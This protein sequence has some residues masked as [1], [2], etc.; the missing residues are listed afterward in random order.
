[1]RRLRFFLAAAVMLAPLSAVTPVSA[2][3][4]GVTRDPFDKNVIARYKAI[5]AKNPHDGSAL[6]KLL[7]MYKRYRTIDLLKEEYG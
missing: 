3:D 5:L 7:E 4:W 1:M 6:A 2:D